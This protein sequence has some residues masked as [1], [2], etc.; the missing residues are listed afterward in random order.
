M[1][2]LSRRV[3][4][5]I[6][7]V[8]VTGSVGVGIW[9]ASSAGAAAVPSD[10]ASTAG[11]PAGRGGPLAAALT[12]LVAAGTITQAQADAI[13]AELSASGRSAKGPGTAPGKP[14]MPPMAGGRA[15]MGPGAGL[16]AAAK[17]LGMTTEGLTAELRACFSNAAVATEKSVAVEA[18]VAATVAAHNDALAQ[19]VKDGKLTQAQAD[20]AAAKLTERTT[21]MVNGGPKAGGPLAPGAGGPKAGGPRGHMGDKGPGRPAGNGPRPAPGAP[22]TSTPPTTAA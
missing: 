17:A 5:G 13:A 15:T 2:S 7:A 14:G 6:A 10:Q 16:D 3:R 20:A 18:V 12:K 1:A 8:A 11:A 22:K 9:F 19:A 21:A 4:T